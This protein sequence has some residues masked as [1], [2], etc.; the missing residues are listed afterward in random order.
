VSILLW[1]LPE[2]P[3]LAAV[4]DALD[5]LGASYLF[6]DQRDIATTRINL[7]VGRSIGGLL[8]GPGMRLPLGEVTAFYLR[9]HDTRR[10]PAVAEAGE[11]SRLWRHALQT[12]EILL[13]WADLTDALV[14][15]RPSAAASNNS[16][17]YQASLIKDFGFAVPDTLITTDPDAIQPFRSDHQAII[18]K[19]ISGV[20]S[21]V[22][23]VSD[24][25]QARF[26]DV[27]WCPTQ[28]QEYV[29]GRDFRV[30]VIGDQVFPS[31]VVSEADDYRY[32]SRGGKS[33]T[34]RAANLPSDVASQCR[35]LAAGLGLAIAGIDL[36]RTP[37]DRWYCFE[38]NP[39]P[40]FSY[41]ENATGQPLALSVARLLQQA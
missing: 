5:G 23:R 38:V 24:N 41:Y 6:L 31:E 7:R 28:F 15:N 3:P 13:S 12:D 36:R 2:D 17:P 32:A 25:D 30:H 29:A 40:G 20:R 4:K 14:I 37:S 33:V 16:K 9:P 27:V 35:S 10:L 21:I 19:S 26:A 39:S 11:N 8:E 1:G 18:Y 22:S 34:I